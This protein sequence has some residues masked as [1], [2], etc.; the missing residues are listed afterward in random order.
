MEEYE[1]PDGS[2]SIMGHRNY[3]KVPMSTPVVR[4]GLLQY[5]GTKPFVR[6]LKKRHDS[7]VS[8]GSQFPGPDLLLHRSVVLG[9]PG[10]TPYARRREDNE[11]TAYKHAKS[12]WYFSPPTPDAIIS[13]IKRPDLG[14]LPICRN[15]YG[16]K[17]LRE[18]SFHEATINQLPVKMPRKF[19]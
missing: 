11:T 7:Q 14:K 8:S 15:D 9:K 13:N 17:R 6:L 1:L 10:S 3:Q 4:K 16:K 12:G 5:T 2:H 19:Y 18:L